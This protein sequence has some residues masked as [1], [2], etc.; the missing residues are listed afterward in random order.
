[1]H[2]DSEGKSRLILAF[3][4]MHVRSLTRIYVYIPSD[5]AWLIMKDEEV[6]KKEYIQ[7]IF[8]IGNLGNV[9]L[10]NTFLLPG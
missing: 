1:M 4:L 6:G 8:W 5:S 3:I 2:F 9:K 10:A 7:A